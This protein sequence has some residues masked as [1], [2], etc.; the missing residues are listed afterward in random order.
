MWWAGHHPTQSAPVDPVKEMQ[1]T[2]ERTGSYTFVGGEI[3]VPHWSQWRTVGGGV[4]PEE[5]GG[6][7]LQSHEP[8]LMEL[9]PE[10]PADH[11]R[12]RAQVRHDETKHRGMAGIFFG[13]T[14]RDDHDGEI[15]GFC[16]L[17]F[18]DCEVLHRPQPLA[19]GNELLLKVDFV[20]KFPTI[21]KRGQAANALITY[22]PACQPP[23]KNPWHQL[24]V[25][26]SPSMVVLFW[27]G[28]K[29]GELP[30]EALNNEIRDQFA[31]EPK[32]RAVDL[33]FAPHGGVGLFIE[34]GIAAFKEVHINRLIE[35]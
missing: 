20:R 7:R 30:Q 28:S 3:N 27:D 29:V 12:F 5:G 34:G 1:E 32:L 18:N 13:L 17:I 16:T 9:M 14:G 24:A 23:G 21:A 35:R 8:C 19:P 26:I 4:L 25:E 33:S 2:L 15:L 11:Y 6:F 22:P 31:S 10:V